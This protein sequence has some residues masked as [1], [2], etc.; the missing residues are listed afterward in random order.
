MSIGVRRLVAA[1]VMVLA[2]AVL[3]GCTA[4]GVIEVR[5]ADEVMIDVTITHG[6]VDEHV[7]AGVGM[8][9]LPLTVTAG[10][11]EDQPRTCRISG[12][13]HPEL[14]HRYLTVSHA[15]ELLVM[16]FN[17]LSVAPGADA[18][19]ESVLSTFSELDLAVRF[20]GQV[21]STTGEADGT[22]AHFRDPKQF[23]R[24]YGLRAEALDHPGPAWSVLG[25][26]AGFLVGAAAAVLAFALWRRR[27]VSDPLG[28]PEESIEAPDSEAWGEPEGEPVVT[29]S[30]PAGQSAVESAQ[31]GQTES[32]PAPD[33]GTSEPVRRR[34]DDSVWAPPDD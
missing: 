24:P 3:S 21:T 23:L 25:P 4:S 17:P 32:P 9:D 8:S 31:F 11:D 7:C 20:P 18:Q 33:R 5:S 30:P 22:V 10:P 1:V 6:L 26:I 27:G 14:L 2:A 13:V 29:G 34:P 12:A 15:G 28:D 19:D 16:T